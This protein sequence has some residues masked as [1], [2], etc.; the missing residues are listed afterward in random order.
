MA[1][2]L[3]NEQEDTSFMELVERLGLAPCLLGNVR[4]HVRSQRHFRSFLERC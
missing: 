1:G 4:G 2:P 3:T